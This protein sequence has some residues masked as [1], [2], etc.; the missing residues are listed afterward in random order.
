MTPPKY[1][2]KQSLLN[3]YNRFQKKMGY[4]Y[5]SEDNQALKWMKEEFQDKMVKYLGKKDFVQKRT[6]MDKVRMKEQINFK[7]G[8]NPLIKLFSRVN[9]KVERGLLW[10]AFALLKL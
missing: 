6:R 2:E 8:M 1:T 7:P 4:D 10:D 5:E 3:T 9:G